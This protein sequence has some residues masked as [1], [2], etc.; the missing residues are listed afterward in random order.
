MFLDMFTSLIPRPKPASLGMRLHVDLLPC[1][2]CN[3]EAPL[4]VTHWYSMLCPVIIVAL[5]GLQY[6]ATNAVLN[7]VCDESQAVM[8]L[9]SILTRKQINHS[10]TTQVHVHV[11]YLSFV[12]T[13]PLSLG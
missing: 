7:T 10:V 5:C 13:N 9:N 2:Y 4:P 1:Q 12:I 11:H 3:S 6:G 8:P